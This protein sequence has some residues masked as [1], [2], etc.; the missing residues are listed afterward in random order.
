MEWV[1]AIPTI[2]IAVN[3][4]WNTAHLPSPDTRILLLPKPDLTLG[5]RL[6][7]FDDPKKLASLPH[8]ALPLPCD[9]AFAFPIITMEAKTGNIVDGRAQ[10]LHNAAMM[11]RNLS[12]FLHIEHLRIFT[13][14]I[15]KNEIE[16]RA[17]WAS[18][19]SSSLEYHFS[20]LGT[21]YLTQEPRDWVK[22]RKSLEKTVQFACK[23]TI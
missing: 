3:A 22:D 17:H 16:T 7:A 14:S 6:N 2:K 12:M 5:I 18:T 10:N 8:F 20:T 23:T 13:M 11:L 4:Q 9:P 15:E 1:Y 21:V 19:N